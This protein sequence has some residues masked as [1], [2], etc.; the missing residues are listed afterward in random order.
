MIEGLAEENQRQAETIQQMRDEIAVLK[1]EKAKPKFKSSKMDEETD[2]AKD[3]ETG[4]ETGDGEKKKR[5]GSAKSSKT[6][7]LA[8]HEERVISPEAPVPPDRDSRDT[9]IS[10]FRVW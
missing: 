4:G 6:A 2:K 7:E 10:S 9:G 8:I 1:G 5:P 3:G